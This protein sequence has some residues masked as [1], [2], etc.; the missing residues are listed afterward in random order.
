MSGLLVLGAGGHGRVVVDTACEMG[1][2]DNIAFLDDRYPELT[3]SL[4][5]PVIGTIEQAGDFLSE[6]SDLVIAI[7]N[8]L[9]RVE[10]I[11]RFAQKGFSFPIIVHPT[12]FISKS[13]EIGCGSVVFAQ[14]AI[15]AGSKLGIGCIVNT[16]ATVDHDCILGDGI[17]ISPGAHLAGA[18]KVGN[19]SWIGL[20]S[21]VIQQISI[22]NGV[23]VGAGAVITNSIPN[24]VTVIGIPGKIVKRHRIEETI[25]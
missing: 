9:L 7:G 10:L 15:N 3:S 24:D 18:V 20:G 13:A 2:W 16:G 1:I 21:S 22:G 19:G 6:Y 17:H 14:S 25:T 23:V 8:N 4:S 12:A 11:E 5:W